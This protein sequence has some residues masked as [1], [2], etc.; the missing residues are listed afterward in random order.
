MTDTV[1]GN[2]SEDVL[3]SVRRLVSDGKGSGS[4]KKDSTSDKLV[5]EPAQRIDIP[6]ADNA[7]EA[8]ET[9]VYMLGFDERTSPTNDA[10]DAIY[11]S[12]PQSEDDN[13]SEAAADQP[14]GSAATLSDKVAA[15]ETAIG[16][17]PDTWEPD[18]SVPDEYS[19][20]QALSMEWDDEI[21]RDATGAVMVP[22]K[23]ALDQIAQRDKETDDQT[24]MAKA[25]PTKGKQPT[26]AASKPDVG[27]DELREL[28][29][30]IVRSEL[31]GELG[32]RITRNLRKL[33]RR[34]INNALAV[35]ELE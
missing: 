34:E 11:D 8:T 9:D 16:N 25:Q 22:V 32:Q 3:S 5:L 26:A 23:A 35:Q 20:T 24:Q 29:R 4:K 19:G 31:Q 30:E 17:I 10:L 6:D 21:E 2:D 28:V 14:K 18:G 7:T 33:V 1:S 15:L 12:L 13:H 27:D